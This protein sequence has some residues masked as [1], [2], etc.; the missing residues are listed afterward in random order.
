M[1]SWHR[2]AAESSALLDR[3]RIPG[4]VLSHLLNSA[5]V[6]VGA[7]ILDVGCGRGELAAYL[8]S[9]GFQATGLD[10]SPENVCE[11]RRQAR[12]CEFHCASIADP[13]PGLRTEFDLVLMR[14]TSAYDCAMLS[15]AAF[16]AT[17]QLVARVCPG[18]C[19]A[20]LAPLSSSAMSAAGH[21]HSCFARHVGALPGDRDF[22][23]ILDGVPVARTVRSLTGRNA[24]GYGFAVLRLPRQPLTRAQWER[25]IETAVRADAAPCCPWSAALSSGFRKKAA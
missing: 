20:F 7:T 15:R 4:R 22:Q 6:G 3:T 16:A 8:D 25:A 21:R 17:W 19:L 13:L 18:G 11:A 1:D 24:T 12:H 2:L 9:L 10:E 5:R 23:E 14:Q